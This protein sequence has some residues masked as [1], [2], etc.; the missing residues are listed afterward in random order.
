MINVSVKL[1]VWPFPMLFPLRKRL[2]PL[3]DHCSYCSVAVPMAV[4]VPSSASSNP[5]RISGMPGT[6]SVQRPVRVGCG[7]SVAGVEAVLHAVSASAAI[8]MPARKLLVV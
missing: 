7:L 3:A 2:S 8:M 6:D 4:A 5:W 1:M